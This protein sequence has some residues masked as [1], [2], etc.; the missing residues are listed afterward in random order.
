M[1]GMLNHRGYYG[2]IEFSQ[3]DMVFHGKVVGIK[4]TLTY[5]GESAQDLVSDFKNAIDEYLEQCARMCIE[6]E[7]PFKGSFNVRINPELH[8][9][10]ALL[11]SQKGESLNSF[12]EE[13]IVNETSRCEMPHHA[14]A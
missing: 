11:A 3:E 2:T 7:K 5:D 1:K 6:P 4:S 13:A 14:Y 10:A 8:R 9:I 12:V